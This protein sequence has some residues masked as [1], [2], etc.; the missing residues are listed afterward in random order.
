MMMQFNPFRH[1]DFW[2]VIKLFRY[3]RIKVIRNKGENG[4]NKVIHYLQSE[5]KE[6]TL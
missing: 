5:R 6:L 3:Y 1:R 2:R 4:E